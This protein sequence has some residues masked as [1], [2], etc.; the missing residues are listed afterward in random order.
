MLNKLESVGMLTASQVDEESK[1]YKR[2]YITLTAILCMV[3][4]AIALIVVLSTNI[5]DMS[6]KAQQITAGSLVLTFLV[7]Q[8]I[9]I[10][11]RL[12]AQ[13]LNSNAKY[14]ENNYMLSELITILEQNPELLQYHDKV[15]EQSRNYTYAEYKIFREYHLSQGRYRELFNLSA[16]KR[17]AKNAE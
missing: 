5:T 13:G 9:G 16:D 14:V 6:T 10:P 15:A 3:I 17:G 7:S 1:K 12:K 4:V 8:F 11:L 2:E